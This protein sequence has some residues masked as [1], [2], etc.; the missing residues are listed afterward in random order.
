MVMRV[1]IYIR[2]SS[3]TQAE[4]GYSLETQLE[5]CRAKAFSIDATSLVVFSDDGYSG[6]FLERPEM[7]RLRSCINTNEF[8]AVVMYDPDRMARNLHHQLLITQEIDKHGA[9]LH[10]VS[11]EFKNTAE[12]MLYFSMRGA[13]AAYEKE[14]IKERTMR[15]KKGKLKKGKILCNAGVYGYD[16]DAENSNYIINED[17]AKVV[18]LVFDTLINEKIGALRIAKKL[19]AMGIPS[20]RHAQYKWIYTSV[21]RMLTNEKYIGQHNAFKN[22]QYMDGIVNGKLKRK[23]KRRD[24]SEWIQVSVPAII[25][26]ATWEKAQLQLQQNKSLS[27]RNTKEIYLLKDILYCGKCGKQ[28]S[29]YW[30]GSYAIRY[31][32]CRSKRA[33]TGPQCGARLIQV[34]MLEQLTWQTLSELCSDEHKLSIYLMQN[35]PQ[36]TEDYTDKIIKL[37]ENEA[38]LIKKREKIM[39]WFSSE[40]ITESEADAQMLELK[41]QIDIIAQERKKLKPPDADGR[42]ANDIRKLF[43]DA[44]KSELDKQGKQHLLRTLIKEIR[45]LRIDNN[46]RNAEIDL[47]IVFR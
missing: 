21:Y 25:D 10:F 9:S 29:T 35:K 32:G 42:T 5:A 16:W 11:E 43:I 23:S 30:T 47:T 31:Y 2:V 26:I 24:E 17:Q 34:G 28:M 14:K 39:Q 18:R 8:D 33:V 36:P 13:F 4:N 41:Q 20:P 37:N 46:Y 12:G 45:A 27:P 1:A 6:E 7:E 15:G 19:N 40:H 3:D 22:Y 38:K 44:T